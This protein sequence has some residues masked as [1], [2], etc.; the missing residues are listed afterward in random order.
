MPENNAQPFQWFPEKIISSFFEAV[1]SLFEVV[2]YGFEAV[3]SLFEVVSNGFEVVSNGFEAVSSLF[4]VVSNKIY[5]FFCYYVKEL[6]V[7]DSVSIITELNF[8]SSE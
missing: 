8:P 7:S 1:S 4:E 3:S 5:I 2:S 6:L